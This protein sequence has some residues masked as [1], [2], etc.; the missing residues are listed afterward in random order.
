ML[1]RD[2]DNKVFLGVCSGLSE[3]FNIDANVIRFIFIIFT[4]FFGVGIIIYLILGFTMS[5]NEDRVVVTKSSK[6]TMKEENT[7]KKTVNIL[8]SEVKDHTKNL[9][10]AFL[11]IG[12]LIL[13]SYFTSIV[14]VLISGV[15]WGLLFVIL[16][17]KLMTGNK[18]ITLP[19]FI[20]ILIL[21]LILTILL[22]YLG[23]YLSGVL[24][25]P[26]NSYF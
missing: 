26:Y 3:Y 17:I 8:D 13:L 23:L 19:S 10:Y 25:Y 20:L 21:A 5:I 6:I 11:T 4:F 18:K 12:I 9:S 2:L 16:G 24:P 15:F 1:K 22:K 7:N 14:S